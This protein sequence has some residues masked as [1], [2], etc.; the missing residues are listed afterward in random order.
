MRIIAGAW[1]GRPLLSP[2]GLDT[3]PTASR[4]REALFSMLVSRVGSFEG[5]A[6]ADFFA[7]SG[8]LGIEAL[9]CGAARQRL[10][11]ERA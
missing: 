1:R 9:S 7:G 4:T 8:S 11:P 6:V 2:P 10:E 3:R 5:L